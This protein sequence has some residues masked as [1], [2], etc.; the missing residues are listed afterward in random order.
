MR[1]PQKFPA[2]IT[3]VMVFLLSMSL[4][5]FLVYPLIPPLVLLGG[6][7]SLGYLTFG[8]DI[9]AVVLVN[10]DSKSQM[11]QG[12]CNSSSSVNGVFQK[13]SNRFNLSTPWPSY[14]LGHFN[15]SRLYESWRPACLHAAVKAMPESNGSRTFFD[16]AW[17]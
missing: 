13:V 3:G 9:K 15:F 11:V 8:K 10:L 17:L 7:G 2:V 12:V 16:L 6:A 5:I 1:E 14:S 4:I